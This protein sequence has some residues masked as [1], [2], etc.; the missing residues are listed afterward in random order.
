MIHLIGATARPSIHGLYFDA[1]ATLISLVAPELDSGSV[2]DAAR[3]V[4]RTARIR[5]V[6]GRRYANASVL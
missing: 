6:N 4:P 2:P 3:S 1:T 5:P